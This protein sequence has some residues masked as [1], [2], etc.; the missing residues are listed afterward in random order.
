MQVLFPG[1][2]ADVGGGFVAPG[3]E[4]GLSDCALQWM[5]EWLTPRGV[6]FQNPL[7]YVPQPNCLATSHATWL[8][9]IWRLLPQGP[10]IFPAGLYLSEEV[11]RRAEAGAVIPDPSLPAGPY[12]PDNLETYLVAGGPAQDVTVV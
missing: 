11:V 10:R 6:T 2:H 3:I 12:A 1:C 8:T 9:G 5:I 4:S 7:V